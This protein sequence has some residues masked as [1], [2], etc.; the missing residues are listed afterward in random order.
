MIIGE[1]FYP[2]ASILQREMDLDL[3]GSS[4][5]WSWQLWWVLV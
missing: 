1:T 2:C 3:D 5:S 4:P